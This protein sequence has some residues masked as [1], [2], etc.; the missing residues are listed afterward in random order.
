[1]GGLFQ[2]FGGRSE[3]FQELGHCPGFDLYSWPQNCH[4]VGGCVMLI[5]LQ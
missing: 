2:L 5:L 3:D 4:G 1:V